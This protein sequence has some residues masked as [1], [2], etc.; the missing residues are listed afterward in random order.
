MFLALDTVR[1][2]CT[3]RKRS[4]NGTYV[5]RYLPKLLFALAAANGIDRE[6]AGEQYDKD[7]DVGALVMRVCR[8]LEN[9]LVTNGYIETLNGSIVILHHGYLLP[10]DNPASELT[11]VLE[12]PMFVQIQ[13]YI[14]T[15][16]KDVIYCS[17]DSGEWFYT[18]DRGHMLE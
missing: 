2:Q 13:E 3:E 17:C 15:Y 18:G 6:T 10:A 5:V 4:K 16:L 11:G 8:F 14:D 12:D 1:A 7:K 9:L